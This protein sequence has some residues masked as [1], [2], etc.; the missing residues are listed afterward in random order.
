MITPLRG[1]PDRVAIVTAAFP[2]WPVILLPLTTN[3]HIRHPLALLTLGPSTVLPDPLH[4]LTASL[5]LST[6]LLPAIVLAGLR[7]A[8]L[9]HA[10][11]L[12]APGFAFSTLLL[13]AI[14]LPCSLHLLSP[15]FTLRALLLA[16]VLLCLSL[17]CLSGLLPACVHLV[18]A[19][20]TASFLLLTHLLHHLLALLAEIRPL[21][22]RLLLACLAA[23]P[24]LSLLRSGLSLHLLLTSATIATHLL[25]RLTASALALDRCSSAA[26]VSAAVPPAAA[27]AL[28]ERIGTGAGDQR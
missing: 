6:L 19:L 26:A 20:L 3:I 16:P 1:L 14:L 27:F 15:G 23:A 11:H 8:V 4:L 9:P 10:L 21:L 13:A 18:P 2:D 17:L 28:G 5:A 25:L 7:P 12:L 22:P 24:L